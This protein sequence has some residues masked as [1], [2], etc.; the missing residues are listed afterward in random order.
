MNIFATLLPAMLSVLAKY[1]APTPEQAAI[2]R[3]NLLT[4]RQADG[5]WPDKTLKTA[6]PTIRRA[7][8]AKNKEKKP[9]DRIRASDV[10]LNEQASLMFAHILA[11]PESQF[12]EHHQLA[13]NSPIDE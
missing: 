1:C 13:M 6:H 8:R 4:T 10:N 5:T 11:I 12:I 2:Q 9:K 3:Q 7:I